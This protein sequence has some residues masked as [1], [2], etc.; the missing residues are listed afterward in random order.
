M[1]YNY[2]INVK[3]LMTTTL[4]RPKHKTRFYVDHDGIIPIIGVDTGKCQ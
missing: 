4:P 3:K 1:N 2:Y